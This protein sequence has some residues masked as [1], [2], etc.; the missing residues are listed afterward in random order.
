MADKIKK[1]AFMITLLLL[2]VLIILA[3]FW[4][5][6]KSEI[7]ELKIDL[8]VGNYTSINLDTDA[9]HFGTVK[10]GKVNTL[11]R[12]VVINNNDNVPKKVRLFVKG[13]LSGLIQISENNFI[14][15]PT[16]NKT[17]SIT[18]IVNPERDYGTYEGMLRAVFQEIKNEEN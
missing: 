11:T 10:K 7:K 2:T 12:E 8:I 6:K 5:D 3:F 15:P 4:T 18:V 14:L 13:D 16:E 17:I 1:M 9:I